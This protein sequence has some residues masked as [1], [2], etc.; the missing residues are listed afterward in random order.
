MNV[1]NGPVIKERN[2]QIRSLGPNSLASK[3]WHSEERK[4]RNFCR[5]SESEPDVE[6]F[7]TTYKNP[8]WVLSKLKSFSCDIYCGA[9]HGDLHPKNIMLSESGVPRIIDFGWTSYDS[10]I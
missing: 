5:A 2:R 4:P 6:E 7:G 8:L 1:H 9:I 10:H 3:G